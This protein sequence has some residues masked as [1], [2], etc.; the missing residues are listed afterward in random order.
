MTLDECRLNTGREVTYANAAGGE[1]TGTLIDV[2]RIYAFVDF[3]YDE[4]PE[5][6]NPARL[7]LVAEGAAP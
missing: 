3:G 4:D 2:G 7:S 5:A 6:V 1:D